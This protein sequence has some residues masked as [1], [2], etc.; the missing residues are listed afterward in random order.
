VAIIFAAAES[1]R[2]Q[3]EQTSLQAFRVITEIGW[4]AVVAWETPRIVG[5][6]VCADFTPKDEP[7]LARTWKQYVLPGVSPEILTLEYLVD[8]TF[9]A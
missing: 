8:F 6:H 4:L 5:L 7:A 9:L 3:P 2:D 1:R